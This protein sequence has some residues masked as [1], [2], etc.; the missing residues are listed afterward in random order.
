MER[1]RGVPSDNNAPSVPMARVLLAMSGGV[2]S[3]VAAALLK[4]DGHDVVGVFMRLGSPGESLDG[5]QSDEA[6]AVPGGAREGAS[7]ASSLRIGHQGC[8]SINDAADARL[9]AAHLG[10]PF[11]VANFKKDFGRII[12][13]FVDEYNAGRT[14]NPC[15]RCNDW[16]K[17]GKLHEYARQIDAD[18]VASGHYARIEPD[19]SGGLA[20]LRGLD[21]DKDQSYVLFGAP[22]ERL[23]RMLLPIGAMRKPA[24]RALAHELGLPVFAKPDS[25]EICFVPDNDY[26]GLVARRSPEAVR[27]GVIM[28]LSGRILGEHPGH[29]HFTVG[30]RRGVRIAM[31][32]PV[33]VVSKDAAANTVTVGPRE[34]LLATGCTAG[35]C[36]WLDEPHDDWRRCRAKIRYNAEPV[37]AEVRAV[38]GVGA[39]PDLEVRFEDPQPAVAPGQAVV[40]YS[41]DR[42]SCGGWIR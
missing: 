9:V 25:Q 30:Q 5:M 38:G 36:N 16:L 19:G 42:V 39:Q 31:G 11:Y 7:G 29:Q 17:F 35:E 18:F 40:C 4:R 3:S 26:A 10:I 12:D 15:V 33:Y 13:Y 41:G 22:R 24:V 23:A 32:E 28:D 8:C 34:A 27:P 6:C 20:L 21:H 37:P 2:D 1:A 14:P